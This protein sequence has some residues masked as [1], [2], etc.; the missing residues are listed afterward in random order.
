MQVPG[1]ATRR[2]QF[3]IVAALAAAAVAVPMAALARPAGLSTLAS[4][5]RPGTVIGPCVSS[6][7]MTWL[8][9]G[10]SGGTLDRMFY[11]IEISNTSTRNCSLNGYPIVWAVSGTGLQVGEPSVPSGTQHQVVLGPG[12]T[13]HAVLAVTPG[14]DIAGCKQRSRSYLQIQLPGQQSK[15]VI[16]G[17]PVTA[18]ANA[19]VLQVGPVQA[20]TGLPGRAGPLASSAGVTSTAP[21]R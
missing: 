20:G 17:M 9:L 4:T 2:W 8:G 15:T 13:A 3:V 1:R 11:P 21:A 10:D 5:R 19:G 7:T 16:T 12:R 18:C 14:R 6:A